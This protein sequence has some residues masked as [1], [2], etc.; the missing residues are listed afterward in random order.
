MRL[1]YGLLI[2][3]TRV[4]HYLVNPP[5]LLG[6]DMTKAEVREFWFEIR[7]RTELVPVRIDPP[8]CLLQKF[9]DELEFSDYLSM[10]IGDV[11]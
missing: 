3:I 8:L 10:Q 4:I 9:R 2:Q 6:E 7:D 1:Q 11:Q 5:S